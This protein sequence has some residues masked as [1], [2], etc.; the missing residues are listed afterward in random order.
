MGHRNHTYIY[1]NLINVG[2]LPKG[3]LVYLYLRVLHYINKFLCGKIIENLSCKLET[4]TSYHFTRK[5]R[6][7]KSP[8]TIRSIIYR[9]SNCFSS[10]H[11]K[12]F[13]EI[14]SIFLIA[15]FNQSRKKQLF[16]QTWYDINLSSH[17]KVIYWFTR[18]AYYHISPL[19]FLLDIKKPIS[20]E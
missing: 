17:N 18:S 15:F 5:M 14:I 13:I 2:G 6:L 19:W 9:Y 20:Y 4:K 12:D 16:F 10:P 8:N 7:W 11:H 1:S 3:V